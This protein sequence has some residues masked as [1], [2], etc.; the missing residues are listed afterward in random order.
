MHP[1]GAHSSEQG[2][3]GPKRLDNRV[4]SLRL[5]AKRRHKKIHG[6]IR[7]WTPRSTDLYEL[8]NDDIQDIAMS[9][10]LTPRKCLGF[11][12]PAEAFLDP[13]EIV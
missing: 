13:L 7:R 5:L 8:T 11:K 4:S 6:R 9:L 1:A 10:N 3:N 12:A 2:L